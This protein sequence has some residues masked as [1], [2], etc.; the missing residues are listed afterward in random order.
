[1]NYKHCAIEDLK[2]YTARQQAKQ[3][4]SER[5]AELNSQLDVKGAN[6]EA[7][8]TSGGEHGDRTLDIIVERDRLK[9]NFKNVC[10][11]I[12][13]T[14]RGL[15]GLLRDELTVLE[16]F[17]ISPRQNCVEDVCEELNISKSQ[18]YRI[19][20]SALYKYTITAYGILDL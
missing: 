9:M 12:T 5:I 14:S 17:Y 16:Y 2:N 10:S 15:S 18:V 3:N 20:D 19:R 11:L 13:I 4:L 7:V 1:M 8:V 6:F